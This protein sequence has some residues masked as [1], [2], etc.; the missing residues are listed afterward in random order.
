MCSKSTRLFRARVGLRLAYDL[1]L[2]LLPP[3]D[4]AERRGDELLRL[5]GEAEREPDRSARGPPPTFVGERDRFGETA[6]WDRRGRRP[7]R[8]ALSTRG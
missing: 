8:D 6:D 5:V 4:C 3:G 1:R 7:R 2:G